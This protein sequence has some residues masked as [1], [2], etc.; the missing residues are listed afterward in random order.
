MHMI[1]LSVHMILS[2]ETNPVGNRA[3]G[4]CP[5]EDNSLEWKASS[6]YSE[7]GFALLAYMGAQI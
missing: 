2:F 3:R 1:K 6:T 4:V 5:C 7:A